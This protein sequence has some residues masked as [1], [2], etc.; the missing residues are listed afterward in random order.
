MK[1]FIQTLKYRELQRHIS[2]KKK[3]FVVNYQ[4]HSYFCRNQ[5]HYSLK[6]Y[7]HENNKTYL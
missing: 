6:N 2:R 5:Y 7:K 3:I 4:K 1:F